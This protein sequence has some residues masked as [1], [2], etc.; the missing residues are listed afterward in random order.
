MTRE[1]LDAFEIAGDH[2]YFVAELAQEAVLK[3]LPL[4]DV[5]KVE[6][7]LRRPAGQFFRLLPDASHVYLI[8][9]GQI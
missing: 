7:I 3:R 9:E 8:S 6:T 1:P 2:L 4:A 5:E